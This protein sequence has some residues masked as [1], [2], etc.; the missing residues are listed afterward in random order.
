MSSNKANRIRKPW[1]DWLG[2]AVMV[3]AGLSALAAFFSAIPA[4]RTAGPDTVWVETWRLFGFILFAGFF[5][6]LAFR[7]QKSAGV[8][9]LVFFHKAAMA[10]SSLFLANAK[11][12]ISAGMIDAILAGLVLVSYLL[13]AGWK[14]WKS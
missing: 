3:L 8:W 1:L 14:S 4:A 9:E 11:D 2:R 7:P 10:V 12:S 5:F 6:L 13:T